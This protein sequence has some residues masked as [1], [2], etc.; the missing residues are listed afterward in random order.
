MKYD[1]CS[2]VPDESACDGWKPRQR[3][4]EST[5]R[6]APGGDRARLQQ[7][8]ARVT[9]ILKDTTRGTRGKQRETC[10]DRTPTRGVPPAHPY[11]QTAERRSV[12][13]LRERGETRKR[14]Q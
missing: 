1:L 5:W 13:H 7:A 4:I 6:Y 8:F 2:R 3:E 11:H 10:K 9:K 12:R 14:C